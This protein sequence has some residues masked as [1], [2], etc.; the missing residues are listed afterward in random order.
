MWTRAAIDLTSAGRG[1]IEV[2]AEHL[3]R[4]SPEVGE[5]ILNYSG[6]AIEA[7]D[8][9]LRFL[10]GELQR[11]S[12]GRMAVD[13]GLFDFLLNRGFGLETDSEA[14]YEEASAEYRRCLA[15]LEKLADSGSWKKMVRSAGSES[16]EMDNLEKWN[17]LIEKIWQETKKSGLAVLPELKE[18]I[19][20]ETPVF[21]RSTV[22]VCGYFPAPV[23]DEAQDAYFFVSPQDEEGNGKT[24]NTAEAALKIAS[25]LYPGRHSLISVRRNL[26]AEFVNITRGGVVEEGWCRYA[27]N[28]LAGCGVFADDRDIK[29]LN[30]HNNLLDALRVMVDVEVNLKGTNEEDAIASLQERSALNEELAQREV[31][32]IGCNPTSSVP[33]FAGRMMIEDLAKKWKKKNPRKKLARFSELYFSLSMLPPAKIRK[34]I[35]VSAK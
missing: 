5:V 7:M 22:Q 27:C 31:R 2:M 4:L 10:I 15:E 17:E 29:I 11:K 14:L 12:D 30:L 18:L 23:L 3:R 6:R 33:A 32:T 35:Q 9:Y 28:L 13:Q 16:G 21:D 8:T 24:V 26:T 20:E 34:K 1:Y 25:E 19:V